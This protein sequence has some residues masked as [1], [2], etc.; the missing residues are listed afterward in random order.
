MDD[1]LIERRPLAVN[2]SAGGGASPERTA[3]C[4]LSGKSLLPDALDV[5]SAFILL[6]KSGRV[7]CSAGLHRMRC[8]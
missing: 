5:P 8:R 4:E 2:L 7:L 6:F 3:L 1:R